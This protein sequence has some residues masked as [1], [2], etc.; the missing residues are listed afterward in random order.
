MSN[1]NALSSLWTFIARSLTVRVV[2]FS[3]FWAIIALV[4][5]ATIISALFRQVSERG[6]DSVLLAHLN[7]VIG[8]V[9]VSDNG[10]LEGN[11]NLD[12]LR[13]S[14]PRS[15]WYWAVEP[16]TNNL[17]TA[18]RSASMTAPVPAPRTLG[19]PHAAT[20]AALAVGGIAWRAGSPPARA[21]REFMMAANDTQPNSLARIA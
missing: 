15:G 7:N 5:I 8:S 6:F 1:R 14:Q 21:A 13:F 17:G 20:S 4:V 12:D 11:P 19:C 18:L 3:S 2:A 16:V 10:V 9:G